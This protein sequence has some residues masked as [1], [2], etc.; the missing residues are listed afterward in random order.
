MILTCIHLY[1][2]VL[3]SDNSTNFV[4]KISK[5]VRV[6]HLMHNIDFKS[7]HDLIHTIL[8]N[9]PDKMH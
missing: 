5:R 3:K 9:M 2:S 4:L 1:N 6:L 8:T 7:F